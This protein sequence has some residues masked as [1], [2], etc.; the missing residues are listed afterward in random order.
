MAEKEKTWLLSFFPLAW[1]GHICL[2]LALGVFGP[3]Q[4]YLAQLVGV[5]PEEINLIWAGRSVG[6]CLTCVVTGHVFRHV[7][8][9][10][11]HKLTFLAFSQIVA[12]IFILLVPWTPNFTCLLAIS[13]GI[14]VGL[15]GFDTADN[16]LVVFTLGPTRSRPFL[17][18]LHAFVAV[19]FVI[20][21]L[22]VQPFLPESTPMEISLVCSSHSSVNASTVSSNSSLLPSSTPSSS[23]SVAS[24]P[25][26]YHEL[27][28]DIAWPYAVI[29][30]AHFATGVGFI[31]LAVCGV[32]MPRYYDTVDS[33]D[34]VQKTDNR[35]NSLNTRYL[36]I[37]AFFYFA[38]SCGIE[39]FFQSQTF[40]FGICGPLQLNISQ[41]AMLS[42]VYFA[43]FLVGRFT[44]VF[45]SSLIS[46][47]YLILSSLIG[48]ILSAII[49]VINASSSPIGLY[50]GT[51]AMGFA[52]SFQF[53][54]G[55]SWLAS[56]VDLT[57]RSSSIAF[58]GA[59]S[60]W[61]VF[62]PIAGLMFGSALGPMA[63]FY[64]TLG[65]TI[66]HTGVFL[67]MWKL[68]CCRK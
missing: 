2:G 15:G 42:T 12:G 4:P 29:T 22:L 6:V 65:C 37:L 41:A 62:P 38:I 59:N 68:S 25:T 35:P 26:T 60:G 19:G 63:I 56:L 13:V 33:N 52:L 28:P 49:L 30:V 23:I 20:G 7:A 31:I 54:S 58:L 44:A 47:E 34:V 66:A 17:Q 1:S 8:T 16:S 11:W 48:C 24:L 46:P 9:A 45:V 53:A 14:G 36:L 61:F 55:Y 40:T 10:T 51:G 3:T 43:C 67:A 32:E 64:L 27:V 5:A 21:S 57:G 50:I 18:S 39:A